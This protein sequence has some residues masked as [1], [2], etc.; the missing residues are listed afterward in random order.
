MHQYY[1]RYWL[2]RFV[3]FLLLIPALPTFSQVSVT[4]IRINVIDESAVEILYDLTGTQ[5]ADSLYLRIRSQSN[6]LLNPAA[7]YLSGDWGQDVAP[8]TNR[9]I[10]WK[11]LENGY[12]LDEPIRATLLIKTAPKA[13]TQPPATTNTVSETAAG[14]DPTEK[15]YRPGG[16][17]FALLSVVAPGVGNIFVQSPRPVIGHRLGIT[18]ACYGLMAY[19]L[20]EKKKS[21]DEYA[22]YEQQRNRIAAQP[23]YDR[24]NGHHHRYYLATR[25]GGAIWITDIVATFIKG[26][27]N[28]KQRAKAAQPK[29]NL[30][31][32]SQAGYP[33]AVFQYKF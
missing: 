24:A 18:A 7:Q 13:G 5:P 28:Q 11:A 6:G 16:P 20:I 12:E 10:L 22:L 32:G 33:V 27:Q 23:F 31:P 17:G 26:V 14:I 8:G 1:T 19:G 25:L 29:L 4:N 2:K 21:R 9:R 15:K 30:L 3:C